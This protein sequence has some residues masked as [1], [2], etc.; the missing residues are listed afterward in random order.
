LKAIRIELLIAT[1]ALLASAAASIATVVQ[2]RVVGQEMSASVWPY[3]TIEDTLSN[4]DYK[5]E[6]INQGLGPAIVQSADLSIDGKPQAN[7]RA[8]LRTIAAKDRH[9]IF[10]GAGESTQIIA[11]HKPGL[12]DA[13]RA[14]YLPKPD[15]AVCYCSILQQCWRVDTLQLEQPRAVRDCGT[16]HA[17]LQY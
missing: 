15:L 2:T 17:M 14:G 8:A 7:W 5:L 4:D 6:V 11:V 3:L 1:L 16:D 9:H 13:V 12:G 10:N